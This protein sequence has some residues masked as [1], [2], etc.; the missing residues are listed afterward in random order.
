MNAGVLTKPCPRRGHW[1]AK[2]QYRGVDFKFKARTYDY[3]HAIGV[4]GEMHG[5]LHMTSAVLFRN[6][7]H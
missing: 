5:R 2:S 7:T 6:R 1:R 3:V 4:S